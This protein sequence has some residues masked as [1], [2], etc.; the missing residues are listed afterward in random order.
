MARDPLSEMLW[1]NI[2]L[3]RGERSKDIA[4]QMLEARRDFLALRLRHEPA[5]RK[6]YQDAADNV[7]KELLKLDGSRT[8]TTAHLG[9]VERTLRREVDKI[10]TSLTALLGTG[11]AQSYAQ[12]ARPLDQY[13][14]QAVRQVN[15]IETLDILKIQRGFGDIN[16]AAVEA[17]WAKTKGGMILSDRIWEQSQ[18]AR[19]SIQNVLQA[20]IAQGRDVVEVARDLTQYVKDG[21]V[22]LAEDYPN[23]MARMGTRVPK[24]LCYESLRL[25]RTEY[26]MAFQEGMYSRTRTNPAA[27]GIQWMLSDAHPEM[28]ICDDL[29]EA[30]LYNMGAGVYPVGQEPTHPHPNCLCYTIPVIVSVDEFTAQLQEWVH[31]PESQP[32]INK[33]YNEF[34]RNIV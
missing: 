6:I 16:T 26:S 32:R 7:A 25:A 31:D 18:D 8:L 28:D 22:T 11:I 33:W 23:M 15:L 5:I 13:L 10:D 17:F 30:D 27:E 12:G 9:T 3:I 4:V 34:Y 2:G 21:A 29:A 14:I 20:G 24:D 19:E 1:K